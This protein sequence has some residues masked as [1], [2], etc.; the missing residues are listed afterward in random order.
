LVVQRPEQNTKEL[1]EIHV[2]GRLLKPQ[3]TA[4]VE[5]HGKLGRVALQ[6]Q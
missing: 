4:V 1:A 2:V 5:V 6:Q 3:A